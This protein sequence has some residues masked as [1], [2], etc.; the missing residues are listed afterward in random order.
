[1]HRN[2]GA[3]IMDSFIWAPAKLKVPIGLATKPRMISSPPW[4]T[5]QGQKTS[6]KDL[7]SIGTHFFLKIDLI[8]A[9][10]A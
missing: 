5:H 4:R 9:V 8:Q 6:G 3:S 2:K 7:S 10:T 1:V